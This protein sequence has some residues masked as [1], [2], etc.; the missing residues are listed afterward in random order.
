MP[1]AQDDKELLESIRHGDRE[2]PPV[3]TARFGFKPFG[4]PAEYRNSV[5]GSVTD[6]EGQPIAGAR[7]DI[8]RFNF[9]TPA[10]VAGDLLGTTPSA[11][12]LA[13]IE[14]GVQQKEATPSMLAAL[15]I[16]SPDFQS[17]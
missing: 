14:K 2:V 12:T 1:S 6:A 15:V 5:G 10:A 11:A 17:R 16:G 3:R 9:K 4:Y 7:V 8:S 13:A